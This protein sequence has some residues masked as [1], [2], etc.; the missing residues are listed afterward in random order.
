MVERLRHYYLFAVDAA[1]IASATYEF[2]CRDEEEAKARA[3]P[4]LEHHENVEIWTHH[5]RVA[6]LRRDDLSAEL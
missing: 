5:R 3:R 6:R 1:G 2:N 4:Y